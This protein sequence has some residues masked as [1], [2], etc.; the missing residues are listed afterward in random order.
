[1]KL[2]QDPERGSRERIRGDHLMYLISARLNSEVCVWNLLTFGRLI[3]Q[4]DLYHDYHG[5][6]GACW[7]QIRQSAQLSPLCHF[8]NFRP[9]LDLMLL[10]DCIIPGTVFRREI[11]QSPWC[12]SQTTYPR[13]WY[14]PSQANLPRG[15]HLCSSYGNTDIQLWKWKSLLKTL[16]NTL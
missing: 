5:T 1:M 3:P 12:W 15:S 16:Q 7:T 4:G 14:L 10:K 6:D 8:P 13:Q 11:Y 9:E 2:P